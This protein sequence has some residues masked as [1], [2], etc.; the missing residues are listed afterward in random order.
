MRIH[1]TSFLLL[2]SIAP[3]PAPAFVTPAQASS[4]F[5][6]RY[7]NYF[8]VTASDGMLIGGEGRTGDSMRY[9]GEH[10]WPGPGSA[11]VL[12]REDRNTGVVMGTV[13]TNGHTYTVLM[14]R[15][16]GE[17]PYQSGGIAKFVTLHGLTRQG[18]P[19][20]PKTYAYLAGWGSPCTV[21]KDDS[22]L[23]DKFDCHFMLTEGVRDPV[24]GEV[25]GF[26][27]KRDVRELLRGQQWQGDY[28]HNR[29][30]KRRIRDAGDI[31]R[32]G[33]QLH[34]F[35]HSPERD[36]GHLPP[37]ETAMHFLWTDVQWWSS[38]QISGEPPA[39]RADEDI[40]H[41]VRRKLKNDDIKVN[42]DQGRVTL[43]GTAKSAV[44][45]HHAYFAAWAPGVTS[46]RN[47]IK[48]QGNDTVGDRDLQ[49]A[50][51]RAYGLDPRTAQ[52][53]PNV[54]VTDGVVTITGAVAG[55]EAK[56][57][58][59]EIPRQFDG[60]K[61]VKNRLKVDD[62][63]ARTESRDVDAVV[64]DIEPIAPDIA[65]HDRELEDDIES[66]LAWSPYVDADRVIVAVRNRTAYLFGTVE[67]EDEMDAAV[68]NAFEAGADRVVNALTIERESEKAG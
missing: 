8:E 40:K 57:A 59:E 23:Y 10:I 44:E 16:G 50:I 55:A 14:N 21:W 28:E 29:N 9:R 33:L 52:E 2:A 27:D 51:K 11:T 31:S 60:V 67:D 12:V 65:R 49:R 37:Y 20:L 3:F 25:P 4:P 41:I 13:R 5:P 34:V 42:V 46:V 53:R 6:S 15:F 56:K 7:G 48:V 18:G 61:G 24:T 22:V 32:M 19:I 45:K 38:P 30:T 36:T 35:A 68:D 62:R 64:F 47:E 58:A 54:D 63:I 17:R 26:P 43:T 66:E 39:G 1:L